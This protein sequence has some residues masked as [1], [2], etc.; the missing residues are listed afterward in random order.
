MNTVRTLFLTLAL[1]LGSVA[2]A[3]ENEAQAPVNIN[4]ASAEILSSQLVGIGPSRA[5]AIVEYRE[6][7]GRF[8]TVEHL[9]EIRGIGTATIERNR[10]RMVID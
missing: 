5:Q 3:A 2:M 8:E 1:V 7:N 6:Q 4:T 9:E 10:D